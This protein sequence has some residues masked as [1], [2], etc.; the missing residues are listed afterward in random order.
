MEQARRDCPRCHSARSVS[1][2]ICQVCLTDMK[3][4]DPRPVRLG[5]AIA[6][7]TLRRE[8]AER[9]LMKVC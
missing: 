6:L 5:T 8:P 9:E 3:P 4:M 2:G 1:N 7:G